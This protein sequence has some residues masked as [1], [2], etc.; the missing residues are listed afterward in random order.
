MKARESLRIA[1]QYELAPTFDID[2]F[3]I[4][5]DSDDR[6]LGPEYVVFYGNVFC[7][8]GA[9]TNAGGVLFGSAP[10]DDEV[11]WVSPR[12]LPRCAE[13][14][15]FVLAIQGAKS[16]VASVPV[17]SSVVVEVT[18]MAQAKGL[19]GTKC[20]V[21]KERARQPLWRS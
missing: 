7:P 20:P 2:L 4:V 21:L 3:S 12:E 10:E 17:L 9:V 11:V 15:Q 16:A 18:S 14:I 5:L 8:R 13:A 19:P 6:C 1:F